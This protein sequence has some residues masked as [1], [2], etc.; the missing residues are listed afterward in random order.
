MAGK[1]GMTT[2]SWVKDFD[3]AF[4]RKIE[5]ENQFLRGYLEERFFSEFRL[6]WRDTSATREREHS[7]VLVSVSSIIY[8]Y[9]YF[10]F[11]RKF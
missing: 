8:S 5:E 9:F 2:K 11:R 3:L 10:S 6:R 4:L 1:L 7:L